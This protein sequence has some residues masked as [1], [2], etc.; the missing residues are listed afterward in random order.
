MKNLKNDK[1]NLLNK[2]DLNDYQKNEKIKNLIVKIK[3]LDEIIP[4]NFGRYGVEKLNLDFSK[5]ADISEIQNKKVL[6][7]Y[8]FPFEAE[9]TLLFLKQYRH[10]KRYYLYH[11]LLKTI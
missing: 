7:L 2:H 10:L 11:F 3:N 8:F 1:K 6:V 5:Y 4:Y 9:K